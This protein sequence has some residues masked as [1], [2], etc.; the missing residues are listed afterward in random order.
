MNRWLKFLNERMPIQAVLIIAAGISL[1]GVYLA[2]RFDGRA[3]ALGGA[4]EAVFLVLLRIMDE[5]KDVEKD[6]VAHPQRP[7]PRGLLSIA[8]V[9][10]AIAILVVVLFALAVVAAALFNLVAGAFLGVGAL[11]LWLMFKE[12]YVGEQLAQ[13][14]MIYALTHQIIE[15][16]IYGFVVVLVRP[17]LAFAPSMLA[18][19]AM[20][21][22]ASMTFEIGRKLDPKAPPILKT[23]LSLYGAPKTAALI[24]LFTVIAAA[25]AH[26]L[27][28][29]GLTVVPQVLV[30]LTLPIL[31]KA[32]DKYKS[33]EGA[34]GLASFIAL[35]AVAIHAWVGW[36]R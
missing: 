13:Y 34:A 31:L 10:R 25:G 18:W 33:I 4:A 29:L 9:D 32:P 19:I 26:A 11:W 12:F 20:N 5:R 16:P 24:A 28:I 15:Y 8:E 30:L 27:G 17:D 21:L 2:G 3:L 23:Y 36:P 7:L 6:R 14:P 1:S 22:G 35:W